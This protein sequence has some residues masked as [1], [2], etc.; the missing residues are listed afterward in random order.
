MASNEN[1]LLIID[2]NAIVH[3]AYHALPPLTNKKGQQLGA[4]YGFLLAFFKSLKDFE[5]KYITACF[6]F[7][8]PTFRKE[9]FKDY[10]AQRPKADQELYDQIPLVKKTLEDLG[11]MVL[12]ERGFEADDLIGTVASMASKEGGGIGNMILSGDNDVLQLVGENTS[13]CILRKGV[14]DAAIFDQGSVFEKYG[15]QPAQLVDY[16]ALRGDPTDNISGVKGIGPKTATELLRNFHSLDRLYEELENGSAGSG[17]I[18]EKMKEMLLCQKEKCLTSK[19]LARIK[20][21]V[22]V[23]FNLALCRW[24]GI[25]KERTAVILENF[26]FFS[27]VKRLLGPE[28]GAP[29]TNPPPDFK[30]NLKLW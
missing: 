26:E 16:K 24:Q 30:K 25:D 19:I 1:T 7:P 28:A 2:G 5:P 4:V 20:T 27:L 6:D 18:S 3:R 23:E 14:K 9:I 11:V 29:S 15:L 12:E 17:K 10:K 21:D 8:A 13:A 22:P